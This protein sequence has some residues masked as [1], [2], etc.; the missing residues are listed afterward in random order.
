MR[1]LGVVILVS[2]LAAGAAGCADSGPRRST[3][4]APPD[5]QSASPAAPVI[6][7]IPK[8]VNEPGYPP[9]GLYTRVEDPAPGVTLPITVLSLAV[10]VL[11]APPG[12]DAPPYVTV[13]YTFDAP[14]GKSGGDMRLKFDRKGVVAYAESVMPVGSTVAYADIQVGVMPNDAAFLRRTTTVK[15]NVDPDRKIVEANER[16]NTLSLRVQPAKRKAPIHI[17][18]NKCTVVR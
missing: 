9:C 6:D 12:P 18:D 2:V 14:A 13:R 10:G 17:T 5:G 3:G 8:L 16:N 11:P 1:R 7:L 15:V 4:A